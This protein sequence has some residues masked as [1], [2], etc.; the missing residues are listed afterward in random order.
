MNAFKYILTFLLLVAIP[1]AAA[2]KRLEVFV[3]GKG[4]TIVQPD[5][6]INACEKSEDFKQMFSSSLPPTHTLIACF[7]ENKEFALFPDVDHTADNPYLQVQTLK[8]LINRN[9]TK[10]EFEQFRASVVSQQ[11]QMFEGMP[12]AAR[13]I[14]KNASKTASKL[15]SSAVELEL[16][17]IIPLGVFSNTEDNIA[18]AL[19][20]KMQV[21]TEDDV[22]LITEVT[23]SNIVLRDEKILIFNATKTYTNNSD[24]ETIQK[25]LVDFSGH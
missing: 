1:V 25:L 21:Q 12:E 4:L 14:I 20:R 6:Y 16:E 11:D 22:V 5:G 8:S 9:I 24:L 7:I 19:I 10:N 15:L 13:K 23:A 17:G 2:N 18:F 3:G